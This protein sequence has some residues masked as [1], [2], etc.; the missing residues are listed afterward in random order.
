MSM[1]GC[2]LTLLYLWKRNLWIKVIAH[3]LVDFIS[4]ML[5]P[6]LLAK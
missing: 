5:T 2:N 1:A 4:F 3:F 6:Y